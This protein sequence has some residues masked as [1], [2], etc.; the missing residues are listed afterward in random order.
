MERE[1]NPYESPQ[2]PIKPN[3]QQRQE[4]H[5]RLAAV[6]ATTSVAIAAACTSYFPLF[7][8]GFQF[9]LLVVGMLIVSIAILVIRV[10]PAL[11][12]IVSGAVSLAIAGT[13]LYR[14]DGWAI[15]G[16]LAIT[17]GVCGLLNAILI[18]RIGK[19]LGI[20]FKER[21]HD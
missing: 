4:G 10:S 9:A 7:Y 13:A 8:P 5:W 18:V 2:N 19:L 21:R 12:G 15:W 16:T 17:G 11:T 14:N 20:W 3:E 6:A 1:T